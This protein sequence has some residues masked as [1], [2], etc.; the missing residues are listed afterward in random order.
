MSAARKPL[1]P[2]DVEMV[3][4]W[5]RDPRAEWVEANLY[6]PTCGAKDMWQLS[7]EGEDYYHQ[8]SATCH[9]C[10]AD[11]CCVGKVDE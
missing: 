6:C 2:E 3:K 9:T 10:G 8:C 11:M 7:D 5:N 1:R 4:A